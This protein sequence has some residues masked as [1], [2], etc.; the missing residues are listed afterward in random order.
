MPVHCWCRR[1]FLATTAVVLVG[2][3]NSRVVVQAV[4][5]SSLRSH[6]S[7][8]TAAAAGAAGVDFVVTLERASHP[9]AEDEVLWNSGVFDAQVH[10]DLPPAWTIA[11]LA[12][13]SL[14]RAKEAVFARMGTSRTVR[15]KGGGETAR[16]DGTSRASSADAEGGG[17]H[18]LRDGGGGGYLVRTVP[19][20]MSREKDLR[21]RL[22]AAAGVDSE[23][24]FIQG[25]RAADALLLV[26]GSHPG[27]HLPLM[28]RLLPD[29]YDELR[30]ATSMRESGHL[31][32]HVAFWAV[33]NPLAEA[34][35]EGVER[36]R[37]KVELGAEVIITQPP[38]VWEPFE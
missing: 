7:L 4:L 16:I 10:P 35:D 23:G 15:G 6:S 36:V 30:L 32:K 11:E 1:Q 29:V 37:K 2:S 22:A 14:R 38:L 17:A 27:R 3:R 31:P 9:D 28:R 19:V 13:Y 18:P 20:Q 26:S 12:R 8:P 21:R 34:D 25:G 24:A 5:S 33:A